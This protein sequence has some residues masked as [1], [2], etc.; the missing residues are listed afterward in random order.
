MANISKVVRNYQVTIPSLIRKA[1]NIKEG[2]LISFELREGEVVIIPVSI[3]KKEQANF[4][5]EKWQRAIRKSE[6]EIEKG[7]YSV[8]RSSKELEQELSGD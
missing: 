3:V 4:F 6:Q 2:D 1:L 5:T 7:K 8:Y